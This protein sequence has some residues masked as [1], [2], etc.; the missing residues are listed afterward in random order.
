MH[1]DLLAALDRP[2]RDAP[3]RLSDYDDERASFSLEVPE[4]FNPVLAI[5]ET[6]AAESPDDP[7]VLTLDGA[8]DVVALQSIAELAQASREAARAF[9]AAGV[10]KGDHVFIMLP[11]VP[12]WYAAMLGA[13]RIGAV[14][15]PGPNLLTAKDISDRIDRAEAVAAVTDVAGAAKVDAAW[16]G[17]TARFC[18]GAGNHAPEGWTDFGAACAAAGDGETPQDPTHRD[19]PLLLYFTSGTVSAPK[20]VQHTQAYG[21]GHVVTARFWHDLRPGDLHWTVTDTGWAKA[22][23]GGLFGQLHELACIVQ[24]ALGKPDADTIFGV[25]ARHGVTSFCAPPT[26]YR[27]LVQGDFGKHDLSKL[28]HCTS[29]GE[30]L[31]PEVIRAWKDG[32]GGL[33]VYDGYGQTETCCVVAN[34]RSM[35]VRPGS[36]GR[37]VPG[38]DMTVVDDDGQPVETGEV[39][40][41]VVRHEPV[42]PVGLFPGY[43][44]DERATEGVFRGP[45]YYTGDKAALDEDGY[46]WFEGRGDDVITSSAYRIGPFE[47]ESAVLAHPAVMECAVVG[48]DDPE[49]TQLVVAICILA[50]GHEGT[51]ELAKDIQDFVK[52]QSAPYKYPRE[53]HFVDELP[54]TVSGKIRRVELRGWLADERLPRGGA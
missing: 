12:E 41:V 18:V 34:Y 44:G 14:P 52:Q 24:V 46:F 21:L 26:L 3:P 20:M 47:V 38:W 1:A 32:T 22:A 8:G 10:T 31:N 36:M 53:V 29:A 54:K 2:G 11:R 13:M 30:P 45:F 48:R 43:H 16:G 4:R 28:R 42:R 9:L 37:P 15:M 7:A 35:E 23:W 33:T 49:R 6:W 27:T 40:N 39:G 17:L 51:P 19:D 5:V 50:P 25:L